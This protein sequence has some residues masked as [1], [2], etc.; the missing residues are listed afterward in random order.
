MRRGINPERSRVI[1]TPPTWDAKSGGF[2]LV[3]GEDPA[4]LDMSWLPVPGAT[5]YRIEVATDPTM[6]RV[7]QRTTTRDPRFTARQP[8]NAALGRT[9]VHVRAV[10]PDGIVGNWSVARPIHPIRFGLPDGASV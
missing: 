5:E 9:W 3:S 4:S 10:S 6:V 7:V 1:P 2:S 8:S